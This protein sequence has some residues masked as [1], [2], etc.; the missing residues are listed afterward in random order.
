MK[1]II[2][3]VFRALAVGYIVKA[4]RNLISKNK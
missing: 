1:N 4:I 2:Q 3:R